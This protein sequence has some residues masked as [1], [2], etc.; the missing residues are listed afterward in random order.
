MSASTQPLGFGAS[1]KKPTINTKSEELKSI[2][3][4][5]AEFIEFA[6][7]N[8]LSEADTISLVERLCVQ[9]GSGKS[10]NQFFALEAATAKSI[11]EGTANK[12]EFF[13]HGTPSSPHFFIAMAELLQHLDIDEAFSFFPLAL[14][15]SVRAVIIRSH[16]SGTMESELARLGRVLRSDADAKRKMRSVLA[17]PIFAM[18]FAVVVCLFICVFVLPNFRPMFEAFSSGAP[19]PFWPSLV[20][21]LSGWLE[22]YWYVPLLVAVGV[23]VVYSFF[24]S[25]FIPAKEIEAYLIFR[26]GGPV[27]RF[28][29]KA[30]IINFLGLYSTLWATGIPIAEA[31]DLCVDTVENLFLRE[32]LF[33]EAQEFRSLKAGYQETYTVLAKVDPV[34]GEHSE[35]YREVKLATD[36]AKVEHLQKA[37]DGW[38]SEMEFER[39]RLTL[40]LQNAALLFVGGIV[41]LIMIMF[42]LPLF[43][44]YGQMAR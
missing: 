40:F 39:E 23:P 4:P 43:T 31:F 2:F 27:S 12:R 21:A 3:G 30:E 25:I 24:R 33:R 34:F 10:I 20:L 28:L 32:R 1:A 44:L 42:F 38:R 26:W 18:V 17:Y 14:K 7:K 13:L 19:L 35:I 22:I 8:R 9:I 15:P 36:E 11:L 6:R 29:I 41:L 5:A 37:L 16:A